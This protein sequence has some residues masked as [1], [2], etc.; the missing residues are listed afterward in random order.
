[1]KQ[2][3]II[4]DQ[5]ELIENTLKSKYI[6]KRFWNIDPKEIVFSDYYINKES[7][8]HKKR[9]T[10][11]LQK[12]FYDRFTKALVSP[13]I[14]NT[15]EDYAGTFW[16]F[17]SMPTEEPAL[18]AAFHPVVSLLKQ[19][20][21][22]D[23]TVVNLAARLEVVKQRTPKLVVLYNVIAESDNLRIQQTRDWI[24]WAKDEKNACLLLATAG[25]EPVD[26]C[27]NRLRILPDY[28]FYSTVH[29][30]IKRFY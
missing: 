4:I 17:S 18:N 2:E 24:Q 6:P 5:E 12:D 7:E 21:A 28:A 1:M 30:S 15:L 14:N 29:T 19:R 10:Q 11:K 8:Q 22:A 27:E 25:N 20:V 3:A 26:F 13:E 23:V 9:V 16:V